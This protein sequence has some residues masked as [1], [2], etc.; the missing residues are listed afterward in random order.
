[1]KNR[2]VKSTLILII[3]GFF[4]KLLGMLIK[5]VMSR[6]LGTEGVGIYMLIMPT[7]TLLIALAQFSFPLTISKFVAE[8]KKNNKNLVFSIIPISLIINIIIIITLVLSSKYLS[9][10]L[11]H[12]PRSYYALISIGLVLPFISISS[13]L[14]GYFFG[15]QRMWPHVISNFTEDIIRLLILIIGIPIF[16]KKG[17]EYAVSFVVLSNIVSELTSILILFVF[18]PKNFSIRKSDIIP[19]KKYIKD[20]FN[21]SVPVTLS[22]LIGSIGYF[23]EPIILTSILTKIGYS[24]NFIVNE[25][26]I[27]NGY[28]MPLLLL[29]SFFT[30]AI[31][32]ALIPIISNSYANRKYEYSKKKVK[33]AIIFSLII[34]IPATI[35]FMLIPQV[36]LQLIYKTNKGINYIKVLAP[37]CLLYYIQ[38]PLASS[39]QAIGKATIAMK[40]TLISMVIRLSL[41][42]IFSSMK[43][44]LWSLV[45]ATS[46]NIIFVTLYDMKYI[47]KELK[48]P[49]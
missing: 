20:V 9:H 31:S 13:I 39:L 28:V 18:L 26:G 6:N 25:Y 19:S 48:S 12:E 37:I 7:F 30:M 11:L 8:D 17:V 45:I 32:Q 49:N 35:M 36:P 5:I 42:A 15:K 47:I 41:I 43:I 40:G 46:V 23:F 34:G 22:R 21:I 33:Q 29:P 3:G 10:N 38:S 44:G 14:R 2:F 1:M 4:T 27:L 24:N 16:L